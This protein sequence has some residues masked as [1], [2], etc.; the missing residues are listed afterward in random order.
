[1]AVTL[2]LSPELKALEDKLVELANAQ[3]ESDA[4]QCLFS[5]PLTLPR[6]R[7]H[8]LQKAIWVLNRRDCWAYAQAKAPFGVKQLI[9]Q[10]EEEELGGDVARGLE[11]HY[12][13]NIRQGEAVGLTAR[14]FADARPTD[15]LFTCMC[16]W[17]SLAKDSPWLKSLASCAALELTNSEEILR[18]K[19]ASRRMAEKV[20]DELG[21]KIGKQQSYQEHI[22]ADV[23]HANILMSVAREHADT[24]LARTQILEGVE[25]SWAIDRVFRG[26][27]GALM[28]SIPE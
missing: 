12:A 27:L 13:L 7:V 4:Y 25:E 10:H 14:D 5:V 26:H 23:E 6:I 18:G 9:W 22:V 15:T 1:M 24:E 2:T 19:S 28:L 3:H 11:D 8:H 16:A 21:I 17:A 20:H